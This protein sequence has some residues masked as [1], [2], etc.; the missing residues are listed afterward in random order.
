MS[1]ND[2]IL[3]NQLLDQ[4]LS[5]I[6]AGLPESEYFEIFSAEQVLK[7]DDLSYDELE[8][9]IIDGGGDGGI[10]SIYLFVNGCGSFETTLGSE[11]S[12]C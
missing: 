8:S 4:R 1:T 6:G 3:L 9:G 7:D 10:D 2:L 11:K 12:R 5:E